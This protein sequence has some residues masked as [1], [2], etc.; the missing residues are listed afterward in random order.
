MRGSLRIAI[1]SLCI[2][3]LA[4][5]A[6]TVQT[7]QLRLAPAAQD[8][9]PETLEVLFFDVGK[10]DS[11]LLRQGEHAMLIDAGTNQQG[12]SIAARLQEEGIQKLDVLLIT[13]EDNDHVGGAHRVLRA[14]EVERVY[15]G[16]I[17]EDRRRMGE[18]LE[19]LESH[20]L[21]AV[22]PVAGDHFMLGSAQVTVIA[23]VGDT[24]RKANDASLVLR[25]DF[26][27]T[28]FLFAA[29]AEDLSLGEMLGATGT[30][31]HL[32]AQVLKAPHH[33]QAHGLSA[34]FF[35][36]VNPQIAVITAEEGDAHVLATLKRLGA[37]VFVTGDGDVKITSDGFQLTAETIPRLP[38][39]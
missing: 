8:K 38:Q 23:P 2:L 4:G 6:A 7:E 3:C 22:T 30:R 14:V 25:V 31:E 39:P 33:G 28:A 21:Q 9:A 35:A 19:A 11:I 15:L 12:R 13:H 27:Q 37:Q 29:D 18:F 26:G 16:R 1:L 17:V 5:C 10:A 20:G 36:A 32:R 24:P 34:S